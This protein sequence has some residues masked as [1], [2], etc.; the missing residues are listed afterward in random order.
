MVSNGIAPHSR[1]G[2]AFGCRITG[3]GIARD[4][5]RICCPAQHTAS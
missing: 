2:G 4:G 1:L 3:L 5:F